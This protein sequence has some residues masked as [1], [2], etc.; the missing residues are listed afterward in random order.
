M[1][2]L[3]TKEYAVETLR[4]ADRTGD[5]ERVYLAIEGLIGQGYE[6]KYLLELYL[7][8]TSL[9]EAESEPEYDADGGVAGYKRFGK[10]LC[11]RVRLGEDSTIS[12]FAKIFYG[13]TS[14]C[15][16]QPIAREIGHEPRFDDWLDAAMLVDDQSYI[17]WRNAVSTYRVY[18]SE[19][20]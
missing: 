16:L 5:V 1:K 12:D 13:A 18:L 7:E 6:E 2:R 15:A 19:T 3:L 17:G 11:G 20:E 9:R 10:W 14:P 4:I 8:Y